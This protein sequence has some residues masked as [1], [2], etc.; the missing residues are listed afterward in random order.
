[1]EELS[2]NVKMQYRTVVLTEST[3]KAQR[4]QNLLTDDGLEAYL[5]EE[6]QNP[7]VKGK[8]AIKRG[9]LKQ[10]FSYPDVGFSVISMG[11]LSEKQGAR[12]KKHKKIKNAERISSFSDIKPG[13]YVVHENHGVGIYHGIVQMMDSDAKR[14]YFKISYK[15]GGI[16]YV[17]TTSLDM[18]QKYVAGEGQEPKLN[19]L[20]GADWQRTKHKVKEGVKKL[21]EDLRLKEQLVTSSTGLSYSKSS[22]F[23][24]KD[25]RQ[26]MKED[27]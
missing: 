23:Y 3:A 15:D 16:L 1:M 6:T 10:G 5:Y 20:A 7:P 8:I 2:A 25:N 27:V 12:R 11:D 4:L 14:D 21:A 26:L 9:S 13:D 17:P 22:I 24:E 19:N 18:L